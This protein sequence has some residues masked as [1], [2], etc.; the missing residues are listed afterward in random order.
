MSLGGQ[1]NQS[2]GRIFAKQLVIMSYLIYEQIMLKK[3][4]A[5]KKQQA[6]IEYL[7]KI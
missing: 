3:Y 2:L 4:M 7:I 1:D 5:L 6:N